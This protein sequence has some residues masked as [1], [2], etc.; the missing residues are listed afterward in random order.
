MCVFCHRGGADTLLG[1]NGLQLS[2]ASKELPL[3]VTNLITLGKINIDREKPES[4]PTDSRV[5]S[6]RKVFGYFQG[7]C[8]HVYKEADYKKQ[9][10]FATAVGIRTRYYRIPGVEDAYYLLPG[11][12]RQSAIYIRS[13]MDDSTRMPPLWSSKLIDEK[14]V[15]ELEHFIQEIS[16]VQK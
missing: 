8:E 9:P 12:L 16:Q 10:Y 7:N 4:I 3:T 5:S 11:S 6:M 2:S 1:V 14:F 15:S 13:R